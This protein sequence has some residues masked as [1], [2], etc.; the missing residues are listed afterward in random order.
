M[1]KT[2]TFFTTTLTTSP[3]T[4]SGFAINFQSA[5][6]SG[7]NF[8]SNQGQSYRDAFLSKDQPN[9]ANQANQANQAIQSARS[10]GLK[11]PH[12]ICEHGYTSNNN[13]CHV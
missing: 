5:G 8:G 6:T 12:L 10:G 13:H 11:W 4:G 2:P 3:T 9:L 7:L 1:P